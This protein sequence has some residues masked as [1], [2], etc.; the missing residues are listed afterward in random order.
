M[1]RKQKTEKPLLCARKTNSTFYWPTKDLSYSQ[2]QPTV[3]NTNTIK[4]L[5][6]LHKLHTHMFYQT[7]IQ[8]QRLSLTAELKIKS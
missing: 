6:K 8:R 4:M 1:P 5:V 2:Q 7:H 3:F